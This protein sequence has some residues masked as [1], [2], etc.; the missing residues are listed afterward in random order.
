MDRNQPSPTAINSQVDQIGALDLGSF[1]RESEGSNPSVP[2]YLV[3]DRGQWRHSV[4]SAE[5]DP[6]LNEYLEK[7]YEGKQEEFAKAQGGWPPS[8]H[9]TSWLKG[10]ERERERSARRFGPEG[11]SAASFFLFYLLSLPKAN[12]KTKF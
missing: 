11:S 4:S 5:V 6:A 10:L 1:A 12:I 8:P 3:W 9:C 7:S 2:N